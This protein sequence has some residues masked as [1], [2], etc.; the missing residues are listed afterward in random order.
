MLTSSLHAR[1]SSFIARV[2]IFGKN[3]DKTPLINVIHIVNMNKYALY[4]YVYSRSIV[5]I[6]EYDANM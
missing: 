4:E 3:K 2:Y 1:T 6:I 5:S